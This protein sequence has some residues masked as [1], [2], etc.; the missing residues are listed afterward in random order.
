MHHFFLEKF[1]DPFTW[2]E[3]RLRYSRS[4]ATS[5]MVGFVIGLGDRHLQ[6]ILIDEQSAD[7][8]HIDLGVAF[9]QGRALPVP[10]TV[11]FRLTRDMVDGLGITGTEGVFRRCCE[12]TMKVL[13]GNA[14]SLM[15]ILQVFLHDPLYQWTLSPLQALQKQDRATT[16]QAEAA[17]GGVAGNR[18]ARHAMLRI[19]QK[20][21]GVERGE[22]LGVEG[23]VAL[24][25][26]EARDPNLLAKLY[27]GWSPWC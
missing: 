13:R 9:D 18:D 5:S 24:L 26:N 3:K 12:E 17:V 16:G 19:R 21:Q 15:T 7:V 8:V 4:L 6:N 25:I 14:S 10:E 1:R 27:V 23:H 20:L 2:F 11:P 22:V